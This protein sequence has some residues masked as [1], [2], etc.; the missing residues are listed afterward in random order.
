MF[1]KKAVEAVAAGAILGTVAVF[2]SPAALV[3]GLL[4]AA[5]YHLTHNDDDDDD[6]DKNNT[7]CLLV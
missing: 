5:A 7:G 3:G 6:D 2:V 1:N 4:G